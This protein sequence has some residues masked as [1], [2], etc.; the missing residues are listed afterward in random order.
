MYCL[1][2]II[3]TYH[4]WYELLSHWMD[5]WHIITL[6]SDWV[7]EGGGN[8]FYAVKNKMWTL[9]VMSY[10]HMYI[11][12]YIVQYQ[13]NY[14]MYLYMYTVNIWTHFTLVWKYMYKTK[15]SY[16]LR[17]CYRK[18]NKNKKHRITILVIWSTKARGLNVC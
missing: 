4:Y 18:Q 2:S 7:S 3:I 16:I 9:K 17:V 11:F 14:I 10:M 6:M 15:L 5:K 13:Q 1:Q 8:E 12:C